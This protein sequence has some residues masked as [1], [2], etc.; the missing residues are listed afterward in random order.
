MP[1]FVSPGVYVIEKDISE[2]TPALNSSIV[3]IVGFASKG[4]TNKA[5]LITNQA[6]LIRIFGEPSEAIYGQGL[7]AALEIL[8]TTNALYFIRAVSE[9]ASDTKDASAVIPFGACAAVAVSGPSTSGTG[10]GIDRALY[11]KIQVYDNAGVAQYPSPKQFSIPAGT[12]S[13]TSSQSQA[14]RKVIGGQ[15]D[16]DVVG[17]FDNNETTT[18]LGLSGHIV[19]KFAGSGSY[20]TVSAYSDSTFTTGLAVLQPVVAVSAVGGTYEAYNVSAVADT[21]TLTVYGATFNST[22]TSSLTYLIESLYAGAG[23]NAG[24]T[25]SGDTSGNSITIRGIGGGNFFVDINDKGSV[26]ENFKAALFSSGAFVEDVINT[27]ETETTSDYIKGNLYKGEAD[28][29][30]VTKLNNFASQVSSLFAT[31]D[32]FGTQGGG[33][34]GTRAT[35]ARYVKPI[36]GTYNLTG[37]TNGIPTAEADKATAL[38]GN[39]A[40]EPKTG[41]YA[42]DDDTLNVGIALVPGVYNQNVQNALITLA[43]TTQ[44]FLALVAPPYGIGTVQDAIDWTNGKSSSTAGARSSAI[45]SS[46]AAVYF[47][48]IKVFS[49]F[50]GMDR[51]YDPTIF[52]ARQMAYTDSVSEPWFAPAGYV[53]GRLTKPTDVEVRLSQGDRDVMYSGGNVVNPI[54]NFPQQGITIFGQRTT[55]RASTALDRINIRRLMI[56][57]RKIILASTRTLVFE[58]N[59]EFTWARVENLLNPFLD[60]I[61]ARRGITEFKVICDSTTNTPVRIDRNEMWCRVLIK[62]TKTA[63]IIVF[64]LNLTNQSADLGTI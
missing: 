42:L 54:V 21:S 2:Y 46:Y 15:L 27:G 49:T 51:W 47:P 6:D 58:P 43:E 11:L 40:T 41:I 7:E 62:P 48:H 63:E 17:V 29:A 22:G 23:Y 37:G 26:I 14:L 24:T 34:A 57:I 32:L 18:G 55:Q 59:D 10:F 33:V 8:E 9:T 44:N 1:N 61:R 30:T 45:N 52:A 16:T 19:S 28:I 12:T 50:D 60:D 3:G 35:W 20:M 56:Y 5:T 39:A 13:L 25:D 53:R 31:G 64:E 4:P 36:A 38:I